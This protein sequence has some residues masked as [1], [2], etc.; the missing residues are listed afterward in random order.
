MAL[1]ALFRWGPTALDASLEGAFSPLAC[2]RGALDEA[3]GRLW[4]R[5]LFGRLFRR[6][7]AVGCRGVAGADVARHFFNRTKQGHAAAVDIEDGAGHQRDD[8]PVRSCD[9]E[10][11]RV[12][13]RDPPQPAIVH[14]EDAEAKFHPVHCAAL[15][16]CE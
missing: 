3:M 10:A 15:Y 9:F 16:T 2:A 12:E 7:S 8:G 1:P 11:A 4:L 6:D 14:S 5:R 13:T